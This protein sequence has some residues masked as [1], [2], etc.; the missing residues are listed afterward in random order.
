[1]K[2]GTSKF[3]ITPEVI[4]ATMLGY[5]VSEHKVR[6][7]ATRLFA[8][9]FYIENENEV[10][11]IVISEF[12]FITPSIKH[13]L[14]KELNHLAPQIPLNDQNVLLIGQHTH[15]APGGYSYHPFYNISANGLKLEV[16]ETYTKG[17]ANAIIEA[18][19]QRTDGRIQFGSGEISPDKKVGFNRSIKAYNTNIDVKPISFENRHLAID[20]EMRLLKFVKKSGKEIGSINW[21]AVHTTSIPNEGREVHSDNKGYASLFLEKEKGRDYVAAFA[22][23]SS[24]DVTPNF[25]PNKKI[26]RSRDF[27]GPFKSNDE[28]AQFNGNIQYEKASE[29]DRSLSVNDEIGQDIKVH[30]KWIDMSGIDIDS[31]FANGFKNAITSHSCMGTEMFA[32]AQ[33]DGKGIPNYLLPVCKTFSRIVKSYEMGLVN[34]PIDKKFKEDLKRKYQAQGIKDILMETGKNKLL[35]STDIKNFILPN[36]TDPIIKVLK[37]FHKKGTFDQ[38]SMTPQVLP[39]QMVQ[40]GTLLI[41]AYPFEISTNAGRRLHDFINDNIDNSI[42][43]DVIIC[44]YA[45]G[46]NGYI[47]TYEEYQAQMYEGAHNVFGQWALSA[48]RQ[49]TFEMLEEMKTG[50]ISPSQDILSKYDNLDL[51]KLM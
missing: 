43:K 16:L 50:D 44:P 26:G 25:I 42:I 22:H 3:D 4:G 47:T 23:G 34:G 35:G 18:Y 6:K 29:I 51:E 27:D 17:I 24:G 12:A 7:I 8:R 38:I 2:I 15:S 30:L 31:K 5:G 9:A 20:R 45:N 41:A 19:N 48:L 28:N 1:M 13:R 49:I 40:I 46:Y 11:C 39:F 36:F 21:F 14:F 32:G 33:S 10:L 37:N